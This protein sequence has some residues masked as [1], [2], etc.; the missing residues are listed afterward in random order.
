MDRKRKITLAVT[1]IILLLITLL[2]V[3]WQSSFLQRLPFSAPNP[4]FNNWEDILS[5][6][7][8][9]TVR[10]YSTGTMKINLSGIMN[11]D[12]ERA[13]D[14]EDLE[15]EIPVN[16]SLIQHHE[17]GTYLIDTGLDSSYV[18]SPNGTIKGLFV[19]SYLGKGSQEPDTHIAAILKREHLDIQGVWLTHLHFDHT[20]GILDLPKDIPY[21]M[22][23]NERYTNFTF[24]MQ[25]DHL[26]G[27]DEL[28]EID[29]AA[30]IELPPFGKGLDVFG[31]GSLWAISS[32]GHSRGHVLYFINGVEDKVL[33]TGDASNT[34]YQ[35][36][37]GIGP[38]Y[39]SSDLEQAQDVLDQIIAFKE[40]YPEVKLVFG[41]DLQSR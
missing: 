28:Y 4:S 17:Y 1:A 13:L 15:V 33:V 36:E 14:I 27:I 34:L 39:F 10:T 2:V 19:K 11:M 30:G 41:H 18:Y 16:V 7:K 3:E 38:G 37:S 23:K 29:F 26:A 32:S 20:A 35:F 21:F 12:H 5:H 25:G 40:L 22:G 24:F 8:P 6:P 9:I 31:D